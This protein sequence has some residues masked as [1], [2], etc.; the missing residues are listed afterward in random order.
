MRAILPALASVPVSPLSDEQ[1]RWLQAGLSQPGGKLPLHDDKGVRIS[2]QTIRSCVQ[3]GLAEPWC[4][5]PI[6]SDT[7][8]CRLTPSG[9]ALVSK[10]PVIRVDFSMWRRDSGDAA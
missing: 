3:A 2:A 6:H 7:M 1:K 10:D 4:V 9:R 8:V 5:N